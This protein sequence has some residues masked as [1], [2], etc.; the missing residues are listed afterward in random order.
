MLAVLSSIPL[1]VFSSKS[2]PFNRRMPPLGAS[3]RY[4]RRSNGCEGF[5]PE[6]TE[7]HAA[8]HVEQAVKY[9]QAQQQIEEHGLLE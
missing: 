8:Y 5:S 4:N 7:T 1:G 9:E 2:L 3:R 6:G